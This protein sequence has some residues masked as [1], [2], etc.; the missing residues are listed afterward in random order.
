LPPARSGRGLGAAAP[1]GAQPGV[2]GGGGVGEE[3]DVPGQRRP[4]RAHR[5]AVD[6]GGPH[7]DPEATVEAGVPAPQ[8]LVALL[9]VQ[10]HETILPHPR[11]YVWRDP[12][13]GVP[14]VERP[15]HGY[16]AAVTDPVQL[17]IE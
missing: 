14:D 1:A 3:V 17:T 9:V 15:A 7:A 4:R 13:M 8:R 5:T 10:A 16:G 11:R 6:A 2:L 12:D